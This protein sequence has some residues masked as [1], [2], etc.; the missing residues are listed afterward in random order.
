MRE[1]I[2]ELANGIWWEPVVELATNVKVRVNICT[3]DI[4][5]VDT[6]PAWKRGPLLPLDCLDSITAHLEMAFHGFGGGSARMTEL[7]EPTMFHCVFS[8]ETIFYSLLSLKGFN[9]TS[10]RKHKEVEQKLLHVSHN[11]SLCVSAYFTLDTVLPSTAHSPL[12]LIAFI[13]LP[14]YSDRLL[15]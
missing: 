12:L 13:A 6:T 11:T 15:Y 1:A 5:F 14:P 2:S 4:F 3:G 8:K 7:V 10:R 9:N